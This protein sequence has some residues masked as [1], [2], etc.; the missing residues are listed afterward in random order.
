VLE[1][2]PN[3]DLTESAGFMRSAEAAGY[4]YEQTLMNY[5]LC[6]VK[7]KEDIKYTFYIA[8]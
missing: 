5:Q 3:P 8:E 4:S 6:M 1:V 7:A 2:N